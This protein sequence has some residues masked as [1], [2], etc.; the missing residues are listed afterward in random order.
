LLYD[1]D[2]TGAVAA[3]QF[4]TLQGVTGTLVSA[5]FVVI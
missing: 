5:D 2:G 4:G 1:A 3:V